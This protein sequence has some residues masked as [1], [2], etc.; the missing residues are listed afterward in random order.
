MATLPCD[1]ELSTHAH[2][3]LR[4]DFPLSGFTEVRYCDEQKRVVCEPLELAQV[5]FLFEGPCSVKTMEP[6]FLDTNPRE[7]MA[8]CLTSRSSEDSSSTVPGT[9]LGMVALA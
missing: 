9:K 7:L 3:F 8:H 1:W 5:R 4:Q 6:P 2:L